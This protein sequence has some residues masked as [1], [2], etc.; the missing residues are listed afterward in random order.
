MGVWPVI[1]RSLV[2]DGC[3]V[4]HRLVLALPPNSPNLG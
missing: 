1:G 2:G 3:L 4:S